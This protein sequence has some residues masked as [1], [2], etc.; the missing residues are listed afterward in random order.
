MTK[1][2]EIENHINIFAQVV[3]AYSTFVG[4]GSALIY[5]TSEI[6]GLTVTIIHLIVL[7]YIAMLL[8]PL[9]FIFSKI[10]RKEEENE[11]KI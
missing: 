6:R 7:I 1:I 5:Y 4:V 9:W 11:K 8:I 2:F 3:I 10:K